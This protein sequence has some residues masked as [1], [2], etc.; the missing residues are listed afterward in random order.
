VHDATVTLVVLTGEI[1]MRCRPQFTRV[2]AETAAGPPRDVTV[3]LSGVSFLS[4]DGLG[5]LLSLRQQAL[6]AGRSLRLVDPPGFVLRAL[7]ITGLSEVFSIVGGAG[8][9]G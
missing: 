6:D 9:P 8:S 7:Y 4:S 1:D 2:L 3:E 5:F